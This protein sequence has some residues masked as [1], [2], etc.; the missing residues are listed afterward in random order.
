MSVNDPSPDLARRL[1]NLPKDL[2][3]KVGKLRDQLPTEDR[4]T[5]SP[6]TGEKAT[7]T[8]ARSEAAIGQKRAR[9]GKAFE[10]QLD[11]TH[12]GMLERREGY[13]IPHYPPTIQVGRWRTFK[14]GGGPCDY[15]GHVNREGEIARTVDRIPVVF[16]AKV[17]GLEHASYVHDPS[18]MHQ[19]DHLSDA[20]SAG[21][22]A[23]LLVYAE[24]IERVF[25]IG[26]REHGPQLL[27]RQGVTLYETTLRGEVIDR[28]LGRDRPVKVYDRTPLLP[29]IPY[30]PGRGW[31]WASLLSYIEVR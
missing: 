23:F 15:S 20:S 11:D 16:D 4:P 19:L 30:T 5:T 10:A 2:V 29:S 1:G 3:E 6:K 31:L 7:P 28:R 26:W 22:T 21:A 27:N 24:Q 9:T 25:V 13:I 8:R 14:K 18:K 12:R 17:V